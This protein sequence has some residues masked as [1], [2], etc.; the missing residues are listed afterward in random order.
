MEVF[1]IPPVLIL[2]PVI[3][4]GYDSFSFDITEKLQE[5]EEQTV[6]VIVRDPTEKQVGAS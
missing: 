1:L 3:T 2:T 4:L 5:G 6:K